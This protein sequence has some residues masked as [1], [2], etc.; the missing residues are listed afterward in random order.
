[1]FCMADGLDCLSTV[2]NDTLVS[3]SKVWYTRTSWFALSRVSSIFVFEHALQEGPRMSI[4][5]YNFGYLTV[6][7]K[8]FEL[9]LIAC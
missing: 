3:D 7:C 6:I 8:N 1:M 4:G 9:I 5:G 2:Q